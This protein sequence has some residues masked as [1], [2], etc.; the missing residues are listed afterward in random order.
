MNDK[1]LG[2]G[3]IGAGAVTQAIH[4][5][6]LARMP[7]Q[8]FVARVMDLDG[9]LAE[10]VAGRVGAAWTSDLDEL[11]GDERVEVVA[12]CSPPFA[13]ADQI[14]AAVAAGKRGILCEK[15]LA[16]SQEQAASIAAATSAGSVPLVVGAMHAFDPAWAVAGS[17]I[18]ELGDVH[19]IRS[20]I[21]LPFNDRFE[22]RATEIV[23]RKPLI[24]SNANDVETRAA[25]LSGGVLGLA[26]HDLPL[27]RTFVPTIDRVQ[28]ATGLDP[29]GYLIS[30]VG[31]GVTVELTGKLQ[32]VWKPEWTLEVAGTDGLL[33]LTFGPSYVHAGSGVARITTKTGVRSFGPFVQDG[34][35]REWAHLGALVAQSE[36]PVQSLQSMIDD[37][38]FA[39]SLADGA[40]DYLREAAA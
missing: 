16:V 26:I 37:V 23:G 22:D 32:Q 13:H 3:F 36:A 7:E 10:S 34:Y 15:P 6:T 38:V 5:P 35:E 1:P 20:S 18:Q 14:L 29:F 11:I 19:T 21:T 4:L 24:R 25:K 8:F 40:S 39:I 27:I 31:G 12:I 33:E 2:V 17:L 30:F 28:F 9:S